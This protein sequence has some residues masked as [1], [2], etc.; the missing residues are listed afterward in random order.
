MTSWMN[1]GNCVHHGADAQVKIENVFV[2]PD[3]HHMP[4][5]TSCFN[6]IAVTR[7]P[8]ADLPVN[9]IVLGDSFVSDLLTRHDALAFHSHGGTHQSST[10]FG[11]RV[12]S[13]SLFLNPFFKSILLLMGVWIVSSFELLGIKL[14][15]IILYIDFTVLR[16]HVS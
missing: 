15:W 8:A 16:F 1:L 12:V 6:A 10:P 3:R 13:H 11:C 7:L 14:I 9:G 5:S 2:T 4:R